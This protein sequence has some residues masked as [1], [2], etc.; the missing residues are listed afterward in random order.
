MVMSVENEKEKVYDCIVL[1][2]GAA[3][4]AAS[5]YLS[6]YRLNHLIFGEVPGG[7]FVDATTVENYP[8]FVS[9][10]GPDLVQAFRDHVESYGISVQPVRIGEIA[11]KGENFVARSERGEAFA[12]KT[13][14]LAMGARHRPLNIPGEDAFLGW[15]VSYCATCDAPLF[16]G[17]VVA[18]VGGGDS[19]VTAA[20]HL[21][22]FAEKVYLVHRRGE[23]A[24]VPAEVER[25]RS[26]KNV[27]PILNNTVKEI[28]GKDAVESVI[29][30]NPI[31]Q[32][33]N[34]PINSIPVDGVFIEIGLIPASSIA[35]ALG[36]GMDENGYIR[37]NPAMATNV[38]GVFA[39]GDLALVTG[40]PP[41]R[42]IVTS[43][44]DGARAAA[45]VY[46]YLRQQVPP[47]DWG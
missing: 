19:A 30:S 13:L 27:V 28:R 3:G 5:I 45:A 43:A 26:L 34:Q 25:M 37:I 38:P 11:K 14:L 44:A 36:V 1:G 2:A 24:A 18:V 12:A 9:V 32:S 40:A 21:A 4:M 41:F 15:G 42:Q 7:Q 22:S 17:K 8:G 39:A 23:Y 47:P 46:Q 20:I 6:R 29:L 33:T 35:K 10:S 31:N 16:K